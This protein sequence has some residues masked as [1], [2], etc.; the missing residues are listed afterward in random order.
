[1]VVPV[2]LVGA[3]VCILILPA[4]LFYYFRISV[5][6]RRQEIQGSVTEEAAD[7]YAHIF[8]PGTKSKGTATASGIAMQQF[9]A[10]HSAR[11][12]LVVATAACLL[13]LVGVGITLLWI[14]DALGLTQSSAGE[15]PAIVLYSF[16]GGYTWSLWELL[17]RGQREDLTPDIVVVIIGRIVA[18]VPLGFAAFAVSAFPLRD[19]REMARRRFTEQIAK[20]PSQI[21]DRESDLR[22]LVP[23]ISTQT[24]ARLEDLGI[25]TVNDLALADPI[26]LMGESGFPLRQIL[27]W[28]DQSILGL[29]VGDKI[30]ELPKLGI[31]GAIE[32]SHFYEAHC[33]ECDDDGAF[34]VDAQGTYVLREN[35]ADDPMVKQL[36]QVLGTTPGFLI[37]L[38]KELEGDPHVQL[39]SQL[40]GV[41]EGTGGAAEE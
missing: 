10:M 14:L 33:L 23:G 24:L 5:A 32:A 9:D 39:L 1:M 18:C 3:I 22:R 41:E 38:L 4:Y 26:W 40:W 13:N 11:R 21:Q 25:T 16:W 27:D 17:N 20:T 28:I 35:L 31:R 36:A 29:Y 34:V 8:V 2:L 7:L 12:Y 30:H 6:A 15:L 37:N 19:L